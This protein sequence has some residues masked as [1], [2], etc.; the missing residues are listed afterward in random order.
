MEIMGWVKVRYLPSTS[1]TDLIRADVTKRVGGLIWKPDGSAEGRS[2]LTTD[3]LGATET[4]TPMLGRSP[5]DPQASVLVQLSG[6]YEI[7]TREGSPQHAFQVCVLVSVVVPPDARPVRG[8][9]W[10]VAVDTPVR[11]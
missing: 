10:R 2:A 3:P 7:R 4:T 1:T 9:A 11:P 6:G 5:C 8:C